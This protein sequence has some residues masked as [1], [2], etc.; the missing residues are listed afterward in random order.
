[1][2]IQLSHVVGN[3]VKNNMLIQ[4]P[5]GMLVQVGIFSKPRP[6]EGLPEIECCALPQPGV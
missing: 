2:P 3:E 6:N 5:P 1:M 4:P